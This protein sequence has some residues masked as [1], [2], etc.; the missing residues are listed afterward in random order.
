MPNINIKSITDAISLV[1]ASIYYKM[2][3][4]DDV[5]NCIIEITKNR[6]E[7]LLRYSLLSQEDLKKDNFLGFLKNKNISLIDN[8]ILKEIKY[9]WKKWE[10]S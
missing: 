8:K 5:Y 10:L 9:R 7:W 4:Q 1:M 2:M 3:K 6:T